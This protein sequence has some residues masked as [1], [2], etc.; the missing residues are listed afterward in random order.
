MFNNRLINGGGMMAILEL[1]E[2]KESA[3]YLLNTGLFGTDAIT[4]QLILDSEENY[5]S[6]RGMPFKK[7][8]GAYESGVAVI[9][10][11]PQYD[12]IGLVKGMT[13]DGTYIRG[14][15]IDIDEINL[16][17]TLNADSTDTSEAE[18]MDV[19]PEQSLNVAIQ[20]VK[21]LRTAYVTDLGKKSESIE[22]HAWSN[23]GEMDMKS[24]LP[25]SIA[26]RIKPYVHAKE[27]Q[28][29]GRGYYIGRREIS[30]NDIDTGFDLG[31][32]TVTE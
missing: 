15:I 4:S 27:G 23:W 28:K 7:I 17:I 16:K 18:E 26:S 9:T 21:Y 1:D 22:K 24:G 29:T 14:Q 19:Y 3:T 25:K 12:M 20:I 6:V 31:E 5:L 10:G 13:V 30:A 8:T 32:V 2:F 11:I